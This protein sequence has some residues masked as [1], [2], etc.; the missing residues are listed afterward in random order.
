MDVL[1]YNLGCLYLDRRNYQIAIHSFSNYLNLEKNMNFEPAWERIGYAFLAI[2]R[3]DLAARSF[4]NVVVLN[5][6]NA[7]AYNTLGLIASAEKNTALAMKHFT[8]SILADAT[9]APPHL[10]TAVLLQRT[11]GNTNLDLA[12]NR[13][14]RYLALAPKAEDAQKVRAQV[15][16]LQQLLSA[17]ASAKT[18]PGTNA[19]A[20][21]PLPDTQK[22]AV[23]ATPPTNQLAQAAPTPEPKPEIV[24][25][26]EAPAQTPAVVVTQLQQTNLPPQQ[27]AAALTPKEAPVEVAAVVPSAPKTNE[28][29]EEVD[30][31]A[32]R[33]TT[34]PVIKEIPQPENAFPR[35]EPP[36]LSLVPTPAPTPT[37]QPAPEKVRVVKVTPASTSSETKPA[38]QDAPEEAQTDKGNFFSRVFGKKRSSESSEKA[39]SSSAIGSEPPSISVVPVDI[40]AEPVSVK[41]TPKEKPAPAP[42]RVY[43]PY[44]YQNPPAAAPGNREEA[45]LLFQ[46]A[47]RA[48]QEKDFP[49]AIEYYSKAI[50]KD[51][52]WFEAYFNMGLACYGSGE[53][54]TSLLAFE[55]ALALKPDSWETRYNFALALNKAD[56]P[57]EAI[58]ELKKV[59]RLKDSYANAWL[60]MG[61]IYQNRFADIDN[62]YNAYQKFITLAP[63][64]PS[65]YTTKIWL[66]QNASKVKPQP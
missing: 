48:H 53:Y 15:S 33:K 31:E 45:Y 9:Y 8:N 59:T 1:Y 64:H 49:T 4:S 42:I 58:V 30:L 50:Q 14:E 27:P 16:S 56:H 20:A 6:Q 36:Q 7:K 37:P 55:N 32:L 61:V 10:N 60:E 65:A 25:E 24:P 52:A 2:Q 29:P 41:E 46:R 13:Y 19:V 66:T 40:P 62:A 22:T 11:G 3:N 34:E 12:L 43:E 5:P 26:K 18:A 39:T 47:F 54:S 35:N 38:A 23:A 63:D 17:Q 21:N 57:N 44:T 28:P 51:P